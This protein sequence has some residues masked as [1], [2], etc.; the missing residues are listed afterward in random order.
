M[1]PVQ[2]EEQRKAD[3]LAESRKQQAKQKEALNAPKD[4]PEGKIPANIDSNFKINEQDKNHVHV[5]TLIKHVDNDRK[6]IVPE[7]KIVI[8]WPRNL[9]SSIAAGMFAMYDEA[10]I[11]HHP[12]PSSID[13]KAPLR[14]V[15]MGP[16]G[17]PIASERGGNDAAA[18]AKLEAR[19]KALA[20]R[21][22]A[23]LESQAAFDAKHAEAMKAMDEKLA[24]MGAINPTKSEAAKED[25]PGTNGGKAAADKVVKEDKAADKP[26]AAA[27]EKTK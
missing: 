19:E 10:R 9:A 4:S 15:L 13:T 22:K 5:Y 21:E 18:A 3:Q 25:E 20:D 27:K 8:L 23:L 11:I 14:P 16:D 7:E 1:P 6:A 2:T 17:Q 12:D 26:A 24:L